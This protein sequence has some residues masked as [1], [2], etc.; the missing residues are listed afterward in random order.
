MLSLIMLTVL[1]SPKAPVLKVSVKP[2]DI[3][4]LRV[5]GEYCFVSHKDIDV[6]VKTKESCDQIMAQARALKPQKPKAK[7]S[8]QGWF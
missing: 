4:A 3:K 8:G 7:K 2:T 5:E 6:E 1:N